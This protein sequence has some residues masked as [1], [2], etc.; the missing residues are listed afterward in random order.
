MKYCRLK[1][2]KDAW[3]LNIRDLEQILD[4]GNIAIQGILEAGDEIECGL[5]IR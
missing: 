3:Q 1:G 5:C 2:S 4:W